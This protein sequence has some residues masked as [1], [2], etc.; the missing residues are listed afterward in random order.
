MGAEAGLSQLI[1][2]KAK[3]AARSGKTLK[4]VMHTPQ[5]RPRFAREA[6]CGF[7]GDECRI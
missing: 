1:K 4:T 6:C 3:G 2:N 5:K 7:S